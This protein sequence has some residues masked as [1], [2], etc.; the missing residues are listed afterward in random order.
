MKWTEMINR[1]S[2]FK[3][4][5]FSKLKSRTRKGI[6]DCLRGRVWQIFGNITALQEKNKNNL[7]QDLISSLEKEKILN[8]NEEGVIIRDLHRTYPN[9]ILFKQKLG[10]GQRSLYRV[11]VTYS[12]FNIN[13]GYVQGMGFI[14]ALFLTYMNEE[15]SFWLLHSL[16]VNYGLEGFFKKDFPEL[17]KCLYVLLSLMKKFLP[18]IYHQLKSKKIY[19]TMYASQWFFTFFASVFDFN[20]LVRL[21]DCLLLEGFKIIYRIALGL[22]KINEKVI[23]TPKNFEE[24]MDKF[25]SLTKNVD[26]D[27]LLKISFSFSFS[28]KDIKRYEERYEKTKNNKEDELIKQVDF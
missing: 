21:F 19:P 2:E 23:L 25:R 4:N 16:L 13:T 17:R 7:Y 28:R 24:L 26:V 3:A 9:H 6:P 12:H 10:G 11:L 27:E 5:H 14:T 22:F 8:D 20:V 15:S 1:Y 18:K